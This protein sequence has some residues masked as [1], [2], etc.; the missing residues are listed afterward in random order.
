MLATFCKVFGSG[1]LQDAKLSSLVLAHC[2]LSNLFCKLTNKF[3][4]LMDSTPKFASCSSCTDAGFCTLGQHWQEICQIFDISSN[5]ILDLL[6]LTI[7]GTKCEDVVCK[8]EQVRG[9]RFETAISFRILH[10]ASCIFQN[11][12]VAKTYFSKRIHKVK[13]QS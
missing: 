13:F 8:Y 2:W 11:L 5:N 4:A 9:L 6:G 12:P 3:K 7:L 10:F 1:H